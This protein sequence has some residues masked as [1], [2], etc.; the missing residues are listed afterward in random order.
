MK[1]ASPKPITAAWRCTICESCF[2]AIIAASPMPCMRWVKL[3]SVSTAVAL[4]Q[5]TRSCSRTM[6][7]SVREFST[8]LR[9]AS[10]TA[11][12]RLRV[13]LNSAEAFFTRSGGSVPSA[14][15]LAGTIANIMPMPR[16]ICGIRSS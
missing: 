4:P 13:R 16:R 6:C 9:T 2:I 1:K 3:L 12:P 15:V 10:P 11:P 8:E 14:M 7:R 5:F